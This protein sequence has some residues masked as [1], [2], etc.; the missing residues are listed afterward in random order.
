MTVVDDM[1][2]SIA[3]GVEAKE[4]VFLDRSG[5]LARRLPMRQM[6]TSWTSLYGAMR[7][8]VPN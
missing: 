4:R 7:G 6:L 3:I 1:A 5:G 2:G 8:T